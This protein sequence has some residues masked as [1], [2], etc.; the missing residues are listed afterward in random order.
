MM[1]PPESLAYALFLTVLFHMTAT[2]AQESEEEGASASIKPEKETTLTEEYRR[3]EAVREFSHQKRKPGTVR[4]PVTKDDPVKKPEKRKRKRW[5]EMDRLPFHRIL[6]V[7]LGFPGYHET[8]NGCLETHP[9][10]GLGI[11]LCGGT[12]LPLMFGGIEYSAWASIAYRF[13]LRRKVLMDGEA[14]NQTS[15]GPAV[16]FRYARV[17]HG[18]GTFLDYTS[19][20]SNAGTLDVMG[21]LEFVH[22]YAPHLGLVLQID[23]GIM[24]ILPVFDAEHIEKPWFE[25]IYPTFRIG[26]GPAF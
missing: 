19:A 12:S 4:E 2:R 8:F 3:Q 21:S 6:D 7:E 9:L 15:L 18:D 13:S 25:H 24:Y 22:W 10:G 16:G 14:I 26:I 1:R 17:A 5:R 23:L 11:G 20:R